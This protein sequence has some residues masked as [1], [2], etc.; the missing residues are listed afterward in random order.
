SNSLKNRAISSGYGRR[1]AVAQSSERDS[2]PSTGITVPLRY[3]AR[4][5]ARKQITSA[6][7]FGRPK[8]RRGIVAIASARERL[9]NPSARRSV[10][11]FPGAIVLTVI[12]Y[13]PT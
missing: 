13:G 1:E 6:T 11:I 2:P 8:R 10:S 5:E 12:P 7:S 3:D 4:S 9:A